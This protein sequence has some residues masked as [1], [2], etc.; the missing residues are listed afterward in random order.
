MY[1]F[2]F[3][4]MPPKSRSSD[5]RVG[6]DRA[7]AVLSHLQASV[8]DPSDDARFTTA[9]SLMNRG[10]DTVTRGERLP[11]SGPIPVPKA[12][13]I[14]VSTQTVSMPGQ[15]A[16]QSKDGAVQIEALQA[17]L[18]DAERRATMA[19]DALAAV[20]TTRIDAMDSQATI[21]AG[22]KKMF[23]ALRDHLFRSTAAARSHR[24]YTSELLMRMEED[25]QYRAVA[26]RELRQALDAQHGGG[27]GL[28]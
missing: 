8:A 22:V 4:F 12:I 16:Y 25:M 21:N 3:L 1:F 10:P 19:E 7:L 27:V 11:I 13:T 20:T 18:A 26:V 28:Q 5:P 15:S 2:L 17:A 14:S 9:S 6:V 23:R 24:E